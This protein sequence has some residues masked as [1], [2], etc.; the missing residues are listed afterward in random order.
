MGLRVHDLEEFIYFDETGIDSLFNQVAPGRLERYSVE[1][2][3]SSETG[4]T[5]G[6]KIGLGSILKRIGLPSVDVEAKGTAKRAKG[7][8][9]TEEF[10][11]TREYRYQYL[12][13]ELGVVATLKRSLDDAWHRALASGS[14]DIFV[15]TAEFAPLPGN[16]SD[17]AWRMTA[18]Q[19]GMLQL[20]DV[21]D[22]AFTLGMSVAKLV[23]M[24]EGQI[25]PASHLAFRMRS[26]GR[27][28]ILGKMDKSKY[29]KPFAVSW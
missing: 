29:I 6:T 21:P 27:F 5:G 11:A 14:G 23:G 15:T 28:R 20:Q 8:R 26:G 18:N 2:S 1:D 16:G 3:G 4:V 22:R 10:V 9:R 12:I 25:A 17:D 24:S 19:S 7:D 13:G